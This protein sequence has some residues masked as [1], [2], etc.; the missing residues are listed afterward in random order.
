MKILFLF[1]LFIDL[2]GHGIAKIRSLRA[3]DKTSRL[4]A[5]FTPGAI[6]SEISGKIAATIFT[7]NK[8]GNIIRNRR[9]PINRRSV[10]QSTRRQ[11]LGNLASSWRGIT[12]SQRNGWNGATGNFPYQNTL[13]ETKFLSGEQL[14]VQFNANLLLI[15]SAVIEDVPA[16]FGFATFVISCTAADAIPAL[17]LVF[18]PSPL[19][20]D[21]NLAVFATPNLSPGIASPNASKFRFLENI[22]PSDTTP[23]DL[24]ATFQALFGDPVEAQKIFIEIRPISVGGQGGTP[25]RT[26]CVVAA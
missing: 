4:F 8:G 19:T 20:A 2:L 9:T 24:L 23:T 1:L 26:S 16:P 11:A 17:S 13:G 15:G 14:Y 18:S 10:A 6:I 12:Q 22:A 3:G 7:R 25:L 21:N 5:K